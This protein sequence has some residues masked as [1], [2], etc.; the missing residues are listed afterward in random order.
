M[1]GVGDRLIGT[2]VALVFLIGGF[3]HGVTLGSSIEAPSNVPLRGMT[4]PTGIDMLS[5]ILGLF[6][7]LSAIVLGVSAARLAV[8][9]LMSVTSSA[10]QS[11]F[12]AGSE[13]LCL[14]SVHARWNL[15]SSDSL[16]QC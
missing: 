12:E 4:G 1:G 5:L 7:L 16:S 10:S 8:L 13:G 15:R 3:V 9:C 11:G 14:A 2:N 6:W